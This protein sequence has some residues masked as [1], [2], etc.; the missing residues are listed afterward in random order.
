MPVG[1]YCFHWCS[2]GELQSFEG[3]EVREVCSAACQLKQLFVFLAAPLMY[4]TNPSIQEDYKTKCANRSSLPVILPSSVL[5]ADGWTQTARVLGLP[6]AGRARE[7]SE[8]SRRCPDLLPAAGRTHHTPAAPESN[9]CV[10]CAGVKMG[11]P[12]SLFAQAKR[13]I[14]C[15][16]MHG[17]P[18]ELE[19][20]CGFHGQCAI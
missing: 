12:C 17:E 4:I 10:S 5:G 9:C 13:F 6:L 16:A 1:K 11:G 18:S 19:E 7:Q 20:T 8:R 15:W 14:F 2:L 3:K